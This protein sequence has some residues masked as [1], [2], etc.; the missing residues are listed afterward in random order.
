MPVRRDFLDLAFVVNSV[1]HSCFWGICFSVSHIL[2]PHICEIASASGKHSKERKLHEDDW[3]LITIWRCRCRF[4]R[5]LGL[6]LSGFS[7]AEFCCLVAKSCLTLYD[8]IDCSPPGSS[9]QVIS[10]ARI[11]EWVA[12]FSSRGSSQHRDQ[13]HIS[14]VYC[15]GRQI[16]YPSTT[17]DNPD[18]IY[19]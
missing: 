12:I 11:L 17:W 10:Q 5:R 3:Q 8:A 15:S 4:L 9:V 7:C 13:T 2:R 16:L 14:C 18:I 6:A 1:K 19:R